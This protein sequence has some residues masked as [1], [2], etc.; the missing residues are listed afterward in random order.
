[1]AKYQTPGVYVEEMSTLPPSVAGVATAIPAFIGFTEKALPQKDEKG[2]AV[3]RISNMLEYEAAFG[4]GARYIKGADIAYKVKIETKEDKTQVITYHPQKTD[5]GFHMYD[6]VRLF[7]ANGGSSCYVISVGQYGTDTYNYNLLKD[8]DKLKEGLTKVEDIDEVTLICMPDAFY[9]S[10]TDFHYQQQTALAQA[11]NLHDRI[12]LLDLKDDNVS[13][14]RN[15]NIGS[16]NLEFGSAYTPNLNPVYTPE[17]AFLPVLAAGVGTDNY[18]ILLKNGDEALTTKLSSL[19]TDGIDILCTLSISQDGKI[20]I[21]E[22]IGI[23]KITLISKDSVGKISSSTKLLHT[24]QSIT[25]QDFLNQDFFNQDFKLR[26]GDTLQVIAHQKEQLTAKGDAQEDIAIT[27]ALNIPEETN[28][29]LLK[30]KEKIDGS[31]KLVNKCVAFNKNDNAWECGDTTI[32]L[33]TTG[34]GNNAK[35]T[36]D[37]SAY[38]NQDKVEEKISVYYYKATAIPNVSFTEEEQAMILRA[39]PECKA[40]ADRVV[41]NFYTVCPPSGAIA[42]IM[43]KTDRYKGVWSAPANVS[44][45]GIKG[46]T[47]YINDDMQ[48]ELNAPIY[49]MGGAHIRRH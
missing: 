32:K 28:K 1:M 2:I 31:D 49:G 48:S 14:F 38:A 13:K 46:I 34:T 9:L 10:Y 29:M 40:Y 41:D 33:K 36:V 18:K 17:L 16:E 26:K 27:V 12:V 47:R 15:G 20:D 21:P 7:F 37:F 22:D 39:I 25:I 11:G 6:S 19:A 45:S 3:K 24:N 42:G 8:K 4:R 23:E 43:A 35:T 44:V 5:A 30:Y